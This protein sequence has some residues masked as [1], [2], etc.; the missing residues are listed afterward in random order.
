[1]HGHRGPV[2]VHAQQQQRGDPAD[3]GHGRAD[4][5]GQRTDRGA[6]GRAQVRGGHGGADCHQ[7]QAHDHGHHD[8]ADERPRRERRG[9]GIASPHF[10]P[11]ADQ[12]DRPDVLHEH[13]AERRAHGLVEGGVAAADRHVGVSQVPGAGV[14]ECQRGRGQNQ[15][16]RDHAEQGH[17]AERELRAPREHHDH[18]GE[19]EAG[20]YTPRR[21]RDLGGADRQP[22]PARQQRHG[23]SHAARAGQ[24]DRPA[25]TDELGREPAQEGVAIAHLAAAR[26]R[27][28]QTAHRDRHHQADHAQQR[29]RGKRAH[30][31]CRD[32]Q[33]EQADRQG[34]RDRQHDGQPERRQAIERAGE[35]VH[36]PA[37]PLAEAQPGRE[38]LV[39]RRAVAPLVGR[40][41]GG[42]VEAQRRADGRHAV[43]R[44]PMA[45]AQRVGELG[46]GFGIVG[47][48][49]GPIR[50]IALQVVHPRAPRRRPMLT[51]RLDVRAIARPRR[52]PG[53][54]VLD[55]VEVGQRGQG[56]RL[57]GA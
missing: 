3:D 16:G 14:Q 36:E 27:L 57:I 28:A 56:P 53:G 43:A 22:D 18:R 49:R 4:L 52:Q 17:R 13:H 24:H 31:A 12:V 2:D 38:Q 26:D 42:I 8:R 50:R 54:A 9:V 37:G 1:M 21:V 46:A 10:P 39:Q 34:H 11:D 30:R 48:E 45:P 7:P 44:E 40:P 6:A 33:A 55:R 35:G 5:V 15:R 51:E 23:A 20:P 32:G 19:D 47:H 25:G 41:H 29:Q